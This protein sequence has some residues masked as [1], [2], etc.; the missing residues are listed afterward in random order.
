M[1]SNPAHYFQTG[2]QLG[3]KVRVIDGMIRSVLAQDDRGKLRKAIEAQ[4]QKASEG[5]LDA[6][7]WIA[8]RLEGKAHQAVSVDTDG[9]PQFQ[10]IRMVVVSPADVVAD[11]PS[12]PVIL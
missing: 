12:L 9:K 11:V 10:V 5:N 4:L 8:C 3:T 2:N 1:A 7:D 6:L